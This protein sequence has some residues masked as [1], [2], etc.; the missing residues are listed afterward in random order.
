MGEVLVRCRSKLRLFGSIFMTKKKHSKIPPNTRNLLRHLTKPS[1]IK[2]KIVL[3]S[4]LI[5]QFHVPFFTFC[6]FAA[7]ILEFRK[8]GPVFASSNRLPKKEGVTL[9]KWCFF[10]LKS[11]LPPFSLFLFLRSS[12]V[13]DFCYSAAWNS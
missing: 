3:F 4:P 12:C 6:L 8:F 1:P 13:C 2:P 7:K 11:T 10:F 5:L 9:P